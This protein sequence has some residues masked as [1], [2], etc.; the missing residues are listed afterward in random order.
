MIFEIDKDTRLFYRVWEPEGIPAAKVV[1]VHGYAEHSG[2]YE[3]AG[4]Y[5]AKS[6]F[7]VYA[8]DHP[9]HGQSSGKK[10]IVSGIKDYALN[11]RHF[12]KFVKNDRGKS[13]V[14]VI[15]H[16]MGGAVAAVYAARFGCDISGLV[17][18]GAAVMPV[19]ML[20]APLRVAAEYLSL[21]T[22]EAVTV[23]LPPEKISRDGAVVSGY[24][25]DPLNY[26]GRIKLKTAVELSKSLKIIKETASDIMEPLLVLH[27]ADDR[28]A[29]PEGSR[30]LYEKASSD[31]KEYKLLPGL[32][33]EIFNEPEKEYVL[34][35]VKTWLKMRI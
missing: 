11:L 21:F 30:L 5:L 23:K 20:C 4:S 29:N 12:V 14:F 18:S 26:N 15:G 8:F 25:N 34:D 6:G 28:L 3:H 16:S 32:K 31:D 19:P 22:P 35:T 10:A 2:R 27:G 17:T 1:I 33:H 9:G 7:R 13:K 24:K